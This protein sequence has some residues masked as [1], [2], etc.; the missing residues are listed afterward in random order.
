MPLASPLRSAATNGELR[1]RDQTDSDHS[2]NRCP[3]RFD[4]SE[5]E[6]HGIANRDGE[7]ESEDDEFPSLCR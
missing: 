4:H 1:G 7:A 2:H 6:Q 5:E 3:S